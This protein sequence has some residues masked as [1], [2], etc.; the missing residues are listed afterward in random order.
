[1]CIF[2]CF[3]LV[4][5]HN[6]FILVYTEIRLRCYMSS[7]KWFHD[8]LREFL[9]ERKITIKSL[10]ANIHMDY[11]LML[12][13]V[14]GERNFDSEIADQVLSATLFDRSDKEELEHLYKTSYVDITD[15]EKIEHIE[16]MF[17]ALYDTSLEKSHIANMYKNK[18][19]EVRKGEK[20]EQVIT[21]ITSAIF[22]TYN[23]AVRDVLLSNKDQTMRMVF[24]L[25]PIDRLLHE[26]YHLIL[27]LR[28][29]LTPKVKLSIIVQVIVDPNE[30]FENLVNFS[31]YIK[32]FTL[33]KFVQVKYEKKKNNQQYRVLIK[34]KII[35]INE[36][37]TRAKIVAAENSDLL[38]KM[39]SDK[40]NLVG[41]IF[42]S[43]DLN[44]YIYGLTKKENYPIE[45]QYAIRHTLSSMSISSELFNRRIVNT[46]KTLKLKAFTGQNMHVVKKYS[47]RNKREEEKIINKTSR[48]T[49]YISKIG[50]EEFVQTGILMDYYELIGVIDDF[51]RVSMLYTTLARIQ[52]G[53]DIRLFDE[54]A[55]LKYPFLGVSRY[56]EVFLDSNE[57]MVAKHINPK[58]CKAPPKNTVN[59]SANSL[60]Y[61]IVIDDKEIIEAF[62]LFYRHIMDVVTEDR[63]MAYLFIR[64][65]ALKYYEES[66]DPEIQKV[67]EQIKLLDEEILEI[68]LSVL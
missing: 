48:I 30:K 29:C 26:M 31:K 19:F 27:A 9:E 60:E 6:Y 44:E 38:I 41:K 17:L 1:M 28:N 43:I 45:D 54:E 34:D 65:L 4:F 47:Y 67:I 35:E 46:L 8:H 23:N 68:E 16:R 21:I 37:A 24:T 39:F 62:K 25:P 40:K 14:H 58:D 57:L 11:L 49:Q 66:K 10:A 2:A 61:A 13:L 18:Y 15:R 51:E 63:H 3:V 52:K 33:N 5:I 55:E 53:Y 56:F 20:L 22:S 42:D 32:Y 12:S 36:Q 59:F 7:I 50:I 64:D